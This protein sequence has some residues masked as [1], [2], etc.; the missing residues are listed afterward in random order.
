MEKAITAARR[1]KFNEEV[2]GR[3]KL[4][5]MTIFVKICL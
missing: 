3:R 5:L 2:F 4:M 1:E